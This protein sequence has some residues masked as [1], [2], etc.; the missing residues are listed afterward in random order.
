VRKGQ[1]L[2]LL[3]ILAHDARTGSKQQF[4]QCRQLTVLML[5]M[6]R[7]RAATSVATKAW[8]SPALN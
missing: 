8:K 6:S 1:Q 4:K 2:F 7:P 5:L 3:L